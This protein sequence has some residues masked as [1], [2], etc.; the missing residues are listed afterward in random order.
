MKKLLLALSL[1]SAAPGAHAQLSGG[2]DIFF[3]PDSTRAV[4]VAFTTGG[5]QLS[6]FSY[7]FGPV[8]VASAAV[9]T[10]SL[11]VTNTGSIA[12]TLAVEVSSQATD[13]G[14]NP[15]GQPLNQ[16][17]VTASTD[18][19]AGVDRFV[20]F[21]VFQSSKPDNA[22]F[23][24]AQHH[25]PPAATCAGATRFKGGQ[26]GLRLPA[27]P[28]DGNS[29]GLWFN[30]FTPTRSSNVKDKRFSVTVTIGGCD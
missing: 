17:W 24:D 28:A 16:H 4:T 3:V 23:A 22:S 8:L 27:N 2:L 12:S 6:T 13:L 18:T 21:A 1:L 5:V 9:A 14:L 19:V 15:Q 20:L 29:A 7:D 10:S 11:T 30:L 26:S 25:V